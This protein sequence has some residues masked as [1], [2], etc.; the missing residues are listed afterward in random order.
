[1]LRVRAPDDGRGGA[2]PAGSPS[3]G[4]PG[5]APPSRSRFRSPRPAG[6]RRPPQFPAAPRPAS[7]PHAVISNTGRLGSTL[8]RRRGAGPDRSCRRFLPAGAS[9]QECR[10]A[11]SPAPGLRVAAMTAWD[12]LGDSSLIRTAPGKKRRH[13]PRQ[14]LLPTLPQGMDGRL[15]G[16]HHLAHRGPDGRPEPAR[17][18]TGHRTSG[19]SSGVP[20][21]RGPRGMARAA[22]SRLTGPAP[23]RPLPPDLGRDS[24]P[25]NRHDHHR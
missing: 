17:R 14:A 19:R 22:R 5:P 13:D 16:L 23:F 7:P 3:R 24:T 21:G 12:D 8:R 25:R 1:V 4:H 6:R 9:W 2:D 10:N 20:A 18:R 11:T 15:R